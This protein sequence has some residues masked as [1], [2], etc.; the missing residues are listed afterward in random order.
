MLP[1]LPKSVPIIVIMEVH[2]ARLLGVDSCLLYTHC[3]KPFG[4]RHSRHVCIEYEKA[5][6]AAPDGGHL[7]NLHGH[8]P[9]R[10]FDC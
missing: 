7:T 9:F 8:T 2:D 1:P 4:E 10:A 6:F 3:Y 5:S